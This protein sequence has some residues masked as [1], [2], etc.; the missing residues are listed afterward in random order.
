MALKDELRGRQE[1]L[2]NGTFKEKI[3]YFFDYYKLHTFLISFVLICVGSLIYKNITKKDII[4][5][6]ILLNVVSGNSADV[7]E[8]MHDDFLEYIEV[9]TKEYDVFFN[10]SLFY[11]IGDDSNE[12]QLSD[13]ES[14][15]AIMVQCAAGDIDFISSPLSAIL[16][17][18]YSE[19]FINLEE[20]LTEEELA[21][22]KPYLLYIDGAVLEKKNEA[23]DNDQ[24]PA[25]ILCP[26]PSKPEE[27][28]EP[29]PVFIDV[30][31]CEEMAD[32]YSAYGSKTLVLGCIA[33]APNPERL[34]DFLAF[35]FDK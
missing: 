23:L 18:G 6:G 5:N 1:L 20:L 19:L 12:T 34:T 13:F 10:S 3:A 22:Y 29:I 35:L 25:E 14:L 31:K 4:L 26:D 9:D 33:N 7:I 11:N 15:Q 32:I 30:T 21:L 27:M 2:K 28:E 17:S 8:D 24:N 16:D